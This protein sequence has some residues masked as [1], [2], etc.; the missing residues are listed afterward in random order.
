MAGVRLGDL[1]LTD[2]HASA[3]ALAQG[4]LPTFTEVAVSYD[5]AHRASSSVSDFC[6][7]GIGFDAGPT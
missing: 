7:N 2:P 6:H 5:A 3:Q 4:W 1:V